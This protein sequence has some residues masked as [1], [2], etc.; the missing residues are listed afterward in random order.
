MRPSHLNP[1]SRI[2]ARSVPNISPPNAARPVSVSVNVMP[3]MN[4][5]P[6]ERR[7]TSKSKLA[8][9]G[10]LFPGDVAG[11]REPTLKEAHAYDDHDID[12]EIQQ[13]CGGERLEH[14]ERKILHRP[15]LSWQFDQNDG[16]CPRRILDCAEK[17][18]S[19]RRP[20]DTT[21]HMQQHITLGLR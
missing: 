5:Y 3:S 2:K 21:R 18:R 13:R 19:Q 20:G 16:D 15:R 9:M 11:D 8:N 1:D 14:L 4:R 12:Q 6:S 17:F 7:M 10:A